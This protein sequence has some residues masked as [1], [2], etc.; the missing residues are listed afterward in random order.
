MPLRRC[1]LCDILS[2]IQMAPR[3]LILNFADIMC[4]AP[5]VIKNL[6]MPH[7][8]ELVEA[9]RL[10]IYRFPA[11]ICARHY[12]PFRFAVVGFSRSRQFI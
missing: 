2:Q 5:R 10:Y 6:T 3:V 7:C 8:L 1:H 9:F 11:Y 4:I 12:L